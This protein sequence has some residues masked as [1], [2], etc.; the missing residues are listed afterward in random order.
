[1]DI[2]DAPP[3][4][5]DRRFLASRAHRY[6]VRCERWLESAGDTD[7]D[8][9]DAADPLTVVRRFSPFILLQIREGNRDVALTAIE[10][11]RVAWLALVKQ[12]AI[13]PHLAEPF[14]TDLVWLKHEV[15]RVLPAEG[16]PTM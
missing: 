13:R 5:I 8:P 12:K 1:M 4:N 16:S 3:A 15:A 7:T 11:S 14:V 9:I 2:R 10:H 6:S